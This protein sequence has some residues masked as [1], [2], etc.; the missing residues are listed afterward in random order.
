MENTEAPDSGVDS[1]ERLPNP[2]GVHSGQWP[3][4]NVHDKEAENNPRKRKLGNNSCLLT[5]LLTYR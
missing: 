1:S 3:G 2:P 5:V 4:N